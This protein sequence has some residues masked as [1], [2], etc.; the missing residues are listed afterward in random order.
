MIPGLEKSEKSESKAD[1][2]QHP[3]MIQLRNSESWTNIEEFQAATKAII[4]T[5]MERMLADFIMIK[6]VTPLNS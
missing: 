4:E 5:E 6:T 3:S 1:A 2:E